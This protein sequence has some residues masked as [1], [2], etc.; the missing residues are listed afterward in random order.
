MP[1]Q[2]EKYRSLLERRV[3][4]FAIPAWP[5]QAL[6]ERVIIYRIPDAAS[7]RETFS[8]GGSIIKPDMTQ[9]T[10][11]DRSPRGVVVS[12]GLQALDILRGHG[13]ELGE[14][15]WFAPHVPY[16]FE[17]EKAGGKPV[18]FYFMN[19]GDIVLSEDVT[20]RIAEKRLWVEFDREKK[21]HVYVSSG[22]TCKRAEPTKSPDDI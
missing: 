7:A 20:V 14:L 12:A 19:A 16:R 11:K 15:V 9:Q 6:Y 8:E 10:Q 13:M 4:E 18:E 2:T 1:K 22:G 21:H 3:A 17:V 5:G